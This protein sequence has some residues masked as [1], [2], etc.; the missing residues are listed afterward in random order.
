MKL[1]EIYYVLLFL[2]IPLL[3]MSQECATQSPANYQTYERTKQERG[4]DRTNI[5]LH[6]EICLNVYYHIVRESNGTG[7]I[8]ESK[9]VEMTALL[10]Q[11]YNPHNLFFN[12]LG[13]DFID[14]TD[15]Y[16]VWD[17]SEFYTLIQVNN[18]AN[19]INIYTTNYIN[20]ASG[21]ADIG[22]QAAVIRGDK[23]LEPTLPHEVGH[24]LNLFHTHHGTVYEA[25]D[26]V[27]QCPELING[28]NSGICGDYVE[29]TPADP[30]LL[31]NDGS[32][33]VDANCNYIG[34][35]GYS[36]DTHNIMSYSRDN[37]K[38]RFTIGQELRMRDAIAAIPALQ[39]VVG[40]SCGVILGDNVTCSDPTTVLTLNYG[41]SPY[42][43]EVVEGSMEILG[44]NTG[45]SVTVGALNSSVSEWGSIE[46]SYGNGG[47]EHFDIW[48]G[49]PL[50]LETGYISGPDVVDTASIV[51]YHYESGEDDE[52]IGATTY[53]WWL[54][55]PYNV[56]SPIDY[57][58]D[59][60]QVPLNLGKSI[61]HVFTGYGENNGYIQVMAKNKCG[62]GGAKIMAVEHGNCTGP[63]CGGSAIVPPDPVP[64]ASNASF[65]L[66]FT[67]Y[68]EGTYYIYI[69]DMYSN[70]V[71]SG[72]SSN[73]EKTVET[74]SIPAG[75]YYLH[76]HDG[77]E[78]Y[79]QQLIITH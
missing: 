26:D 56:I 67:T 51:A 7:G 32:Y 15:L 42:L 29:D 22:N 65:S 44:S 17:D 75:T 30:G 61:S 50:A 28:S 58:G 38:D 21:Q 8:D 77:N 6:P 25:G 72:V 66:D 40:N 3:S 27:N 34:G 71:Y 54:P 49:E 64:N 16:N 52:E 73:I 31:N 60:W 43:W 1:K 57:F 13:F 55:Y 63:G 19:A 47:M 45:S 9:L 39:N 36:P 76:I 59:N 33:K 11:E 18:Q 37:C 74:A 35:G 12:Q 10:N 14:N 4:F 5:E 68:P 62:L 48:I 79:T 69:Y 78:I 41:T 46:V 20:N 23:V 2:I 70:A 53:E 24:C